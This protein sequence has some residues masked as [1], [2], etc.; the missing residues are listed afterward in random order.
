MAKALGIV[1]VAAMSASVGH[2]AVTPTT[3]AARPLESVRWGGHVFTDRNQLSSWLEARGQSYREWAAN[4]PN[5]AS[6]LEERA[7]RA[8]RKFVI[9]RLALVALAAMLLITA[10][11]PERLFRVARTPAML[12]EH[13]AGLAMMGLGVAAGAAAAHL[14]SLAPDLPVP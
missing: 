7:A 9:A 12:T 5:A 14:L 4:H 13:R 2:A 10:G 8:N 3:P 6:V 1:V 11:L